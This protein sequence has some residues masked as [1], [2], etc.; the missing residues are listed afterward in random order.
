MQITIPEPLQ[1]F[2]QGRVAEL[3]FDQPDQYIEQLLEEDWRKKRDE[4]YMEKVR[5]GLASGPMIPITDELWDE[6]VDEVEQELYGRSKV[7][8]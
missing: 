8:Q 1:R 6:I 3:G 4:Y 5:E 2:V 7:A